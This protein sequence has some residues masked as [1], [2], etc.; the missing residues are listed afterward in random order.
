MSLTEKGENRRGQSV[1]LVIPLVVTR[2]DCVCSTQFD[3]VHRLTP[4]IPLL[5]EGF[6]LLGQKT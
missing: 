5:S 4:I 1:N 6:T 3:E 2:A